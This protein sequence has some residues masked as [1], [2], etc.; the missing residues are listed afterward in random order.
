MDILKHRHDILLPPGV[1]TTAVKYIMSLIF[2][3]LTQ[4]RLAVRYLSVPS[5]RVKESKKNDEKQR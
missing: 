2:W 4:H 5:S 1:D 3:D